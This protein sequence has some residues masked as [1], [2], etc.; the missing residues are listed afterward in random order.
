MKFIP[1]VNTAIL[2]AA[3][4]VSG[5]MSMA[6]TYTVSVDKIGIDTGAFMKTGIGYNNSQK[7]TVLRFKEGEQVTINVKNNL[8]ESTSIHWH[9]LILPFRQDGVPDISFDGIKPGQTFTYQFPI[10]QAGTY[11][12]HSHSGFQE[13]DGA[14]GAIVIDPKDGETVR[15]DHDYVVQLTDKHP[16]SGD[17]GFRDLKMTD[18]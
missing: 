3:L 16:H 8:R 10:Q 6:G 1:L 9:G 18:E 4:V 5:G 2:A 13:P 11:W 15:V 7:P 12:F 17:R 14:F